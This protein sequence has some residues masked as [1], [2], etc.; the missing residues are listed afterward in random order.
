MKLYNVFPFPS[1]HDSYVYYTSLIDLYKCTDN[2]HQ[3]PLQVS[4]IDLPQ[5]D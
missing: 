5:I 3:D 2:H 4:Q 1:F